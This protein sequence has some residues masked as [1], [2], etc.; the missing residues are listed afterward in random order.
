[1]TKF[2]KYLFLALLVNYGLIISIHYLIRPFWFRKVED[3]T[4]LADFEMFSIIIIVPVFLV[5]FNYW[6]SKK[7]NQKT[8]FFI[9]SILIFSCICIAAKL[10]FLNWADSV[11]S[12]TNPDSETIEVM[13]F[14]RDCGIIMVVIGLIIT[15]LKLYRKRNTQILTQKASS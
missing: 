5:L 15:Y 11:G 3:H 7:I 12:R 14:E 9:N 10:N 6:L 1:M 2:L 4:N 13:Y 8:F